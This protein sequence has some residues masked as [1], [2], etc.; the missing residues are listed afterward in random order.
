MLFAI[1]LHFALLSVYLMASKD[2]RGKEPAISVFYYS[3]WKNCYSSFALSPLFVLIIVVG[4][5]IIGFILAFLNSLILQP[6]A[7]KVALSFNLSTAPVI[8]TWVVGIVLAI[9]GVVLYT[10]VT[11][12]T[13][14]VHWVKKK[15]L[16]AIVIVFFV[17]MMNELPRMEAQGV[18]L[19]EWVLRSVE[20][21]NFVSVLL[22]ALALLLFSWSILVQPRLNN[23]QKYRPG[24]FTPPH[25]KEKIKTLSA[26]DQA[27]H[28]LRTDHQ[29]L[30][31]TAQEFVD[32]LKD[33]APLIKEEPALSTYWNQRDQI[34]QALKQE[35]DG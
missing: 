7:G 16:Q 1:P 12:D 13:R 8:V 30:S 35:R 24:S 21:A 4:L 33:I 32:V 34:E 22:V 25:W 11:R 26:S 15:N 18:Y 10:L 14:I 5:T 31:I 9:I 27:S 17:F 28:L 2:I 29:S 3:A 20:V 23:R 6:I 19:P